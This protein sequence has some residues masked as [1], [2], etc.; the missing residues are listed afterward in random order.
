MLRQRLA[1][2]ME[3]RRDAKLGSQVLGVAGQLP[4]GPGHGLEQQSVERPLVDPHAGSAQMGEGKDDVAVGNREQA[5][6]LGGQPL[7]PRCPL[8]LGTVPIA[9][10][11]VREL[12]GPTPLTDLALSP[13]S[14]RAAGRNRL[15][16]LLL[17]VRDLRG[18][19]EGYPL[20]PHDSSY[21][22]VRALGV[23]AGA[24]RCRGRRRPRQGLRRLGCGEQ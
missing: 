2:G 22:K 4:Q 12:L 16:D 19:A 14:G 10:G 20:L 21:L 9:T 23:G 8:A 3:H 11:V 17:L 18:G 5:R 6:L 15:P 1:P 7:G 13:E 24:C